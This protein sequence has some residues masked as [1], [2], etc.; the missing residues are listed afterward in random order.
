M[1]R[2][3]EAR[4]DAR[5]AD[6]LTGAIGAPF[7]GRDRYAAAMYFYQRGLLSDRCL[8]VYRSCSIIDGENPK[9]ALANL[10]LLHEVERIEKLSQSPPLSNET[11]ERTASRRAAS[12][13]ATKGAT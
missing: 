8:E 5:Q 13:T 7:S 10:G 12:P 4:E 11:S 9:A 2:R 6:I 3:D 1:G